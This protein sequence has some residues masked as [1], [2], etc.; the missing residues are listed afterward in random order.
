MRFPRTPFNTLC[1]TLCFHGYFQEAV[2]EKRDEHYRVR[3]CKI[4]FF[5]EDDTIEVIEP[6]KENSGIPQGRFGTL[7]PC[8][9]LL[10]ETPS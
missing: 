10:L 7:E 4:Y 3:E 5:P 8:V 1:Q 9:L 2:H 6:R